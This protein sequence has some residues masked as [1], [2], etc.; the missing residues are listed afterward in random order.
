[1]EP[2]TGVGRWGALL[3]TAAADY[4]PW[5]TSSTSDESLNIGLVLLEKA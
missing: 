3:Y 2:P 5:S 4:E 1:M